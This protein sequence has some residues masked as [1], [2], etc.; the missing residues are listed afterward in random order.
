[1][2]EHKNATC[3]DRTPN[4]TKKH[5]LKTKTKTKKTALV[6]CI[7]KSVFKEGAFII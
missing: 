7:Q 3:Y 6:Y 2:E 4:S 1:M 5:Q